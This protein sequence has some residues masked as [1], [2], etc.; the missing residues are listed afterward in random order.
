MFHFQGVCDTYRLANLSSADFSDYGR[1]N[2]DYFVSANS[3]QSSATTVAFVGRGPDRRPVLYVGTTYTGAV[4]TSVRQTVPAVS[5]RSLDGGAS[6]VGSQTGAGRFR[7]THV[8]GLTGGGTLVRL[9]SEAI[10][11]FR[12]SYVA[13]FE[14]PPSDEPGFAHFLTVQPDRFVM[15]NYGMPPIVSTERSSRIVRVCESDRSFYSYVEMPIRC[16]ANAALGTGVDGSTTTSSSATAPVDYNL[17]RSAVLVRAGTVLAAKL[18]VS[19]NDHVLVAVFSA[20]VPSGGGIGRGQGDR[21]GD[22]FSNRSA[23]CL[24][25]YADV[26]K[27][28][29]ENIRR[30]FA[31][32]QR[33]VGLQFG[34]R[35]CVSLVSDMSYASE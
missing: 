27:K 2:T 11:K 35:M 5:S 7:F 24:Y 3:P 4:P 6:G 25:R 1:G 12:I 31:G 20:S 30:C 28:F 18:G 13:G 16:R 21:D 26:R 32:E 17:I 29:T 15:D 33:P 8:D 10:D 9:R 19:T 34:N 22:F 23:V 14:S